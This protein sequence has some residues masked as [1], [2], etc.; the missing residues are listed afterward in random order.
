MAFVQI[1]D[2]KT[3]RIDDMNRLMDQWVERTKGRRTAT[4]NII[5]KDRSDSSHY[6][7]IIEFPSYEEAMKNSNLTETDET[8]QQIV[9]LCDG[10]PTFTDLDVVRDEQ[11]NKETARRF[12]QE[13]AVGGNLDLIDGLFAPDYLDHDII[14]P[15]DTTGSAAIRDDVVGWRAAFDFD[16]TIDD[17]V[18]EGDTVVTRWTWRG[19]HHGDFMGLAATGKLCTMTGTTVFR[20]AGDRIQ[21]GWWTYDVLG[22]MRQ[23]GMAG[24]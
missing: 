13:V 7:E 5:G 22:L 2:C 20:F 9:A 24:A 18:A 8:F 1:M 6:I 15:E 10:M 16:F 11:L 12:Y 19:T 17:Q 23:L 4:H 14:K 21:E 3:S